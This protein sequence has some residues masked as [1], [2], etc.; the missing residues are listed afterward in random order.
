[1]VLGLLVLTAGLFV[2]LPKYPDPGPIS[3]SAAPDVRV[4]VRLEELITDRGGGMTA[5]SG[6]TESPFE[7]ACGSIFNPR[8]FGSAGVPQTSAVRMER[9]WMTMK[10][11]ADASM[12]L[13]AP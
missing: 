2:P 5:T 3:E 6:T 10:E 11:A 8:K 1:M 13:S 4:D 12:L 7:T 9:F